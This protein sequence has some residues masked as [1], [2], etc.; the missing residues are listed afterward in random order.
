[1]YRW[2]PDGYLYNISTE[3]RVIKNSKSA[4][5]PR[6]WAV[7]FQAIWNQQLKYQA[8]ANVTKILKEIFSLSGNSCNLN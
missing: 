4:G 8:R 2:M 7:N 5:T 1:M 3:E 6:Y